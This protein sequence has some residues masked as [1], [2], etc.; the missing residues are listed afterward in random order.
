MGKFYADRMFLESGGNE[1][2]DIETM[3]LTVNE[4]L[5]R[6]ETMTRSRRSA[7]FTKGNKAISMNVTLGVESDKAQIN[8]ALKDPAATLTLVAEIGG[9]RF[10]F[11]DVEQ[12]QMTASGT[13]GTA[14]KTL[15]LEAIDFVDENGRSRLSDLGL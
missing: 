1:I 2:V 12:S 4:N 6:K 11:I 5:T 8:I 3:D 9:D 14:S 13:V 10:S 15:A 7:G